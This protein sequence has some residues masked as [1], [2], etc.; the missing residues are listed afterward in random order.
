[1]PAENQ[2][3]RTAWRRE[4]EYIG[5]F[6]L[7]GGCHFIAA[8]RKVVGQACRVVQGQAATLSKH[9]PA[10]D[11]VIGNLRFEGGALCSLVITYAATNRIWTLSVLGEHGSVEVNGTKRS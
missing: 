3:A 7:D 2:F 1:M 11:T 10:P 8:I 4:P 5:G 6:L 9:L